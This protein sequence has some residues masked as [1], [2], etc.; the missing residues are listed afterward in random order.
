MPK[1]KFHLLVRFVCV[2]GPNSLER[3]RGVLT[4][5]YS[6]YWFPVAAVT[7]FQNWGGLKQQILFSCGFTGPSK[8]WMW[9]SSQNSSGCCGC[10]LYFAFWVNDYDTP[11]SAFAFVGSLCL[12]STLHFLQGESYFKTGNPNG[13]SR[14]VLSQNSWLDFSWLLP[15]IRSHPQVLEIKRH[16]LE[17]TG[18]QNWPRIFTDFFFLFIIYSTI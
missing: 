13:W 1:N 6:L 8:C 2:P 12:S 5:M 16:I 15:Q 14:I 10:H 18:S 7:N 17:G 4:S 9:E 11:S 3:K